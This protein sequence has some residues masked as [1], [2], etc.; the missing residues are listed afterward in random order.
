VV[1]ETGIRKG[2]FNPV[3]WV[4]VEPPAGV[5]ELHVVDMGIDRFFDTRD[6]FLVGEMLK[7]NPGVFGMETYFG[8]PVHAKI[9]FDPAL[10]NPT[11]LKSLIEA[12]SI[13]YAEGDQMVTERTPFKVEYIE[14][15][16]TTIDTREYLQKTFRPFN[17]STGDFD[18]Y[19][20][21]QISIYEM[22]FA[23]AIRQDKQRWFIF[24]FS[25]LT[26]DDGVVRMS[27]Q[28]AEDS[29]ELNIYYVNEITNTESIHEMLVQ[30]N[31]TVHYADGST[32]DFPNPY[33]FE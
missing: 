1:D 32:R 15:E 17:R 3:S 13:T 23:E 24:L 14:P 21:S 29:P 7:L 9:Y 22:P 10:A 4:L 19:E 5:Q 28:W 26:A 8:E 27:V 11:E 33:A 16:I 31:L 30:E 12:G 2:I 18:N 25:H 20:E 6:A